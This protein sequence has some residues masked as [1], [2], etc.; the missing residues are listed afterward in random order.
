MPK[1]GL[2]QVH[3]SLDLYGPSSWVI[4]DTDY[5][6]Y[7][8]LCTCQSAGLIVTTLHRRSCTILGRE[9]IRKAETMK[10]VKH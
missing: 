10:Q 5:S 3:V 1:E 8:L 7:A 6:D 2:D 4:M 9:P